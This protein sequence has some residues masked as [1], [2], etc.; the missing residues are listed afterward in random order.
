MRTIDLFEA[1]LNEEFNDFRKSFQ[2]KK[3]LE[4]IKLVNEKGDV[5]IPS[6][7]T[8]NDIYDINEK[9]SFSMNCNEE[10]N[11]INVDRLF[12]AISDRVKTLKNV[13]NV[14]GL[15][16]I[17]KFFMKNYKNNKFA[18]ILIFNDDFVMNI[19]HPLNLW[20]LRNEKIKLPEKFNIFIFEFK[21][22]IPLKE[23]IVEDAYKMHALY[24]TLFTQHIIEKA[25]YRIKIIRSETDFRD[26]Y[27]LAATEAY[28]KIEKEMSHNFNTVLFP[29]Q[30]LSRGELIPYAGWGAIDV[31]DDIRAIDTHGLITGNLKGYHYSDSQS[32]CTGN[33]PTNSIEGWYTLSKVNVNSTWFSNYVHIFY[34]EI[35]YAANKLAYEVLIGEFDKLLNE[36]K[37]KKEKE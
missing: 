11:Y 1:V 36:I 2:N 20:L 18:G 25:E 22:E 33:K 3:N 34:R 17:F 32:V 8:S 23:K 15:E 16:F 12:D 37:E 26:I 4:N 30:I 28:V 14:K 27:S 24:L 9:I 10:D 5:L 29:L 6:S 7:L 21:E 13:D 35:Y 19:T 31:S